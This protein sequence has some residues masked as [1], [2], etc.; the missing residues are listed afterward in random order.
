MISLEGVSKRYG[1][2]SVLEKVSLNISQ[3]DRIGLIGPNGAGKT[4]L[5]ELIVGH[6]SPDEG[7]LSKGPGTKIGYL[8]QETVKFE[9]KPLLEN[10]LESNT[11][12]T[13]VKVQLKS[14]EEKLNTRPAQGVSSRLAEAYGEILQRFETL[15]G[16]Q[17][18]ARAKKILSGLGFKEADWLRDMNEFSGGWRM[19]AA[20]AKLLLS[21][22]DLLLLDEPTN[23]LDL[24]S[25]IWLEEFL[26]EYSGAY[27]IISHDRHFLNK[28]VKR[29]IEIDHAR[30]Y[31][32]AGNY[33]DYVGQKNVRTEIL[34]ATYKNQEKKIDAQKRFI[35]RFRYKATK[36][37]QV[38][39]RLKMLEKMEKVTLP[40]KNRTVQFQ[41]PPPPRS[42]YEVAEIKGLSK[43]YGVNRVYHDVNLTIYRGDKI[44]FV[45]PNG[46]GKST[47]LKILAGTLDYEAGEFTLGLNVSRAYFAQHQLEL[48]TADNQVLEELWAVAP[49][50][51][52][53]QI[54]SL[55]GSFL[56]TQDDISK[57]VAVLSGGEKSRLALAKMLLQPHNFL[58]LDEPTNHLDI[59]SRDALEGALK[60]YQGTLCMITHDRHLINCLANK[61]IEIEAGRLSLYLGNYDDYLYKK[62]LEKN[63]SAVTP[64]NPPLSNAFIQQIPSMEQVKAGKANTPGPVNSIEPSAEKAERLEQSR[65]R[66]EL[67]RRQSSLRNK[68]N[69]TEIRLDELFA[70]RGS[71]ENLLSDPDLFRREQ[72]LYASS[73]QELNELKSGIAALS[74]EWERLVHELEELD[75]IAGSESP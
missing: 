71:L 54:R 33:D 58:L 66:K 53:T 14:I 70:R 68:I 19:R 67:Q 24:A 23:H 36:A 60:Q 38:Q 8:P 32:Y 49:T 73:T 30:I 45:G 64:A 44:A 39:S 65:R 22:P 62:G 59:P 41:F 25:L 29:I 37:R 50:Y 20:L 40:E 52:Q 7:K 47:L 31:E 17:I 15:G 56:F 4:T 72:S 11:E 63:R 12:I 9:K 21:A 2:E 26:G 51:P 61:V 18:E 1:P 42:G 34:E 43:S 69:Q 74:E 13:A 35:E 27:I 57:K 48:L 75:A 3:N 46:A 5:F 10:V 28:M 55:L 6:S 16:Y